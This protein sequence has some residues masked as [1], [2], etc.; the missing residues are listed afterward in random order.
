M[1]RRYILRHTFSGMRCCRKRTGFE[2]S[3]LQ[4]INIFALVKRSLFCDLFTSLVYT[5][6][7]NL[8]ENLSQRHLSLYEE[9]LQRVLIFFDF[10]F[11]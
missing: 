5:G 6:D 2:C 10:M 11:Y 1:T 9:L 4:F 7:K 3:G 8:N